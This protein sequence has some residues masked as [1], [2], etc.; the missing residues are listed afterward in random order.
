MA[1]TP[2]LYSMPSSGNSYKVRL[3]C[4]LLCRSY[5]HVAC[6]AGSDA[7]ARARR[8]GKAPHGKLPSLE[9][10]DGEVLTESNAILCYLADGSDWFPAARLTRAR[11]LAWMFFEQN[12]LEPVI[13]VRASLRSYPD[14]KAEATPERMAALLRDGDVVLDLLDAALTGREWLV[15][16]TPSIADVALYG[17]THSAESRGGYDLARRAAVAAWLGRIAGLPGY[18]AL[19]DLPA[20]PS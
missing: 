20:C 16:T 7:L 12:R 5:R 13:A 10:A 18:V 11:T 6:E 2:T 9:L 8:D 4:G 3:L 19:E 1:E 15:G 14:R 17:Y